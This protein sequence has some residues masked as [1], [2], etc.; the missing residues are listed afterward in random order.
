[1]STR[2]QTRGQG[3]GKCGGSGALHPARWKQGKHEIRQWRNVSWLKAA[4]KREGRVEKRSELSI[5]AEAR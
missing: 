4:R 1:M 2:K 3:G 5:D